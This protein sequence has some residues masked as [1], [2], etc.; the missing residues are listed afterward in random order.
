[1]CVALCCVVL[2]RLVVVC[3]DL[4]KNGNGGGEG[5][6]Q[7]SRT[8]LYETITTAAVPAMGLTYTILHRTAPDTCTS[9]IQ[10]VPNPSPSHPKHPPFP[11]SPPLPDPAQQTTL[12][13][14]PPPP[15]KTHTRTR[16]ETE[17]TINAM[18]RPRP[19]RHPFWPQGRTASAYRGDVERC[20]T[21]GGDVP[22]RVRGMGVAC[23]DCLV[24]I[25][26]ADWVPIACCLVEIPIRAGEEGSRGMWGGRRLTLLSY[27]GITVGQGGDE[28]PS[29]HPSIDRARTHPR[30]SHC[31]PPTTHNPPPSSRP[32][33]TTP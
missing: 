19:P 25:W 10:R 14:L 18:S 17:Q 5:G 11:S 3:K 30:I 8:L 20:R 13:T 33:H 2:L 16:G 4:A 12:P 22:C 28:Q 26:R 23:S 32:H 29:R 24:I 31:D 21:G 9:P 1:M 7:R 15:P 27:H 6:F